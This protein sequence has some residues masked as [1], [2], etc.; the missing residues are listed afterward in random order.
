MTARETQESIT[1]WCD[2]FPP[3]PVG[4]VELRIV[5]LLE[6]VVELAVA[7][8]VDRARLL[9]VVNICFDKSAPDWGREDEIP[10]EAADVLIALYCLAT[11]AG[12][13]LHAVVDARMIRNRARPAEYYARKTAAKAELGL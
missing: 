5:R 7:A 8:G 13:D 10:G 4:E 9:E 3:K 6:E 12:F 11:R 1:A 2:V